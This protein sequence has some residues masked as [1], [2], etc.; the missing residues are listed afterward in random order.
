MRVPRS[1]VL[2]VTAVAALSRSPLLAQQA[3]PLTFPDLE[4]AGAEGGAVRL[5]QLKGNVVLL[6]VWATWCGPCRMEL[7]IV[8]R[9]YDKYSDRN[10]VVLAIN[11]D[12]DRNRVIPFLKR[13]NISLPIYYATPEYAGQMTAM[14]IPSTC[15]LAPDRKVLDQQVGF[16][17]EVEEHCKQLIEKNSRQRKGSR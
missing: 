11:I 13:L 5:S 14:A 15:V 8:Q 12:A 2:A 1:L 4:F 10:F 9:L 3:E 6:N 16:S 17:P 7:P